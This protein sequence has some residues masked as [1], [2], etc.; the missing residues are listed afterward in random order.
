MQSGHFP[1]EKALTFEILKE[2]LLERVD[3]IDWT[4]AKTD[5]QPFL[6][7]SRS[8]DVWSSELFRSA[9]E[10]FTRRIKTADSK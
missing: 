2:K 1:A 6:F 8:V 9:A 5:V 3:N 10:E 7:D 4:Q